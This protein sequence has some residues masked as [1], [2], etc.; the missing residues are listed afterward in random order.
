MLALAEMAKLALQSINALSTMVDAMQMLNVH[1]MEWTPY[2]EVNSDQPLAF[3]KRASEAMVALA[4]LSSLPRLPSTIVSSTTV[5]VIA[6]P[7][8]AAVDLV[9]WY[10]LARVV[11]KAMDTLA[12]LLSLRLHPPPTSVKLAMVDVIH[13]HRVR[14]TISA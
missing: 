5:D 8:A 9:P 4:S 7:I 2:V 14:A 3:A 11:S 1:A 12:Q 13:S 10:A 6:M